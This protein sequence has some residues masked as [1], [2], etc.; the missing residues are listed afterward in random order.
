M[1][2]V[3]RPRKN[4]KTT[5]GEVINGLRKR[6][7]GRWYDIEDDYI[8]AGA[9]VG[10]REAIRLFNQRRGIKEIRIVKGELSEI[11]FKIIADDNT[12][13]AEITDRTREYR[14]DIEFYKAHRVPE[15][16]LIDIFVGWLE[17]K[18]KWLAGKTGIE[19]LAYLNDIKRPEKLTLAK[20]LRT[21]EQHEMSADETRR[22]RKIWNDFTKKVKKT[23]IEDIAEEDIDRWGKWVTRKGGYARKTQ[24]HILNKVQSILKYAKPRHKKNANAIDIV[25]LDISA[26]IKRP[27]KPKAKPTPLYP[28]EFKSILEEANTKWKAIILFSLN[29]GLHAS[30]VATALKEEISYKYKSFATERTKTGVDRCAHLWD[31]TIMAVR[32][33]RKEYSNKSKYLFVNGEGKRFNRWSINDNFKRICDKAG[34]KGYSFDCMRDSCRTWMKGDPEAAAF[35]MGHE[36]DIS[37]NYAARLPEHTIDVL[38]KV[39]QKYLM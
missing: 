32:K 5:W 39:R 26:L 12:S 19:Q 4:Y 17:K 23:T 38:A 24:L 29:C 25:K 11:E 30:E 33:Y 37:T 28:D 20:V 15:N 27:K 35:V 7:D 8:F 1:A 2:K 14:D 34:V 6:T 10:E 18:P 31:E 22:S 9:A 13:V 21:Y 3:G 36:F 16:H